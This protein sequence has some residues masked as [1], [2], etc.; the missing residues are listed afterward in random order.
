ME[1]EFTPDAEDDFAALP[2]RIAGQ[3]VRKLDRLRTGLV[4][5]IKRL[6]K[7]AAGYRLRSGDYRILFSLAGDTVVVERIKHRRHA[8]D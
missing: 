7:A 6:H 1:V 2:P 4:G 5:D 3:V 8:Y